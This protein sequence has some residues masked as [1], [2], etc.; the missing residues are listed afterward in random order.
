MCASLLILLFIVEPLVVFFGEGSASQPIH[1]ID[2]VCAG[3]EPTLLNCTRGT[4]IT[5]DCSHDEDVGLICS[6]RS[7][8]TCIIISLL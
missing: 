2:T 4:N 8:G 3:S 5:Y 7:Q 1:I 6:E